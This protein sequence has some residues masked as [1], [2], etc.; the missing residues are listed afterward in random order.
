MRHA[1]Q[2]EQWQM[3]PLRKGL[4]KVP[5]L[6]EELRRGAHPDMEPVRLH[7]REESVTHPESKA[8]SEE[9][10]SEQRL[11]PRLSCAGI[12]DLRV[13]PNGGKQ[14][15]SLINLS[16]RGCCFLADQP[17]AGCEGSSIEIHMKVRGIPFRVAGVIRHVHRG[18]KA[19]IEFV[20][21]SER[22]CAQIDEVVAELTI[23]DLHAKKL[24]QEELRKRDEEN[25]AEENR[26]EARKKV[27]DHARRRLLR[28]YQP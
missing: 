3:T 17:L 19:G 26:R 25:V 21:L 27:E 28:F 5:P 10:G 9:P 11:Y 7:P 6:A 20:S 2:S 18:V 23:L 24:R 12:A 22:K 4:K 14:T 8:A 13:I 1:L 15:G 16:K